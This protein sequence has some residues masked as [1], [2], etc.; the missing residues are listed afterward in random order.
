M[1]QMVSLAAFPSL[2]ARE[3]L[4]EETAAVAL[5]LLERLVLGEPILLASQP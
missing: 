2:P 3:L 4:V 1:G 5:R